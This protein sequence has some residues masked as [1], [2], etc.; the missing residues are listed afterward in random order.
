MDDKKH[1]VRIFPR[2]QSL[3]REIGIRTPG[4]GSWLDSGEW[5]RDCFLFYFPF[6][7]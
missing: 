1:S 3:I 2:G 4:F 7:S 5:G 6:V